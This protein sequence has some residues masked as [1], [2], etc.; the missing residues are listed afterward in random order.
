MILLDTNVISAMMQATPEPAVL[1][2]LNAQQA[3]LIWTTAISVFEVRFGLAIMPTGRR[4]RALQEAFE[5]ALSQD[6]KGQVLEFGLA[7]AKEAATIAAKLQAAG[8]P[9]E[10]RDV[11]IAGTV[12]AQNGT[13]ATRNTKHFAD[14][15]IRL[16][17]PWSTAS[18]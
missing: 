9:I 2:W 5:N 14:T 8:R 1:S 6:L 15:G 18:P 17:N 16:V 10:M 12:A 7:A 4:Q 3:S 13:L 11:M